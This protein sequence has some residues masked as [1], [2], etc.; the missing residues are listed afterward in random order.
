MGLL[1]EPETLVGAVGASRDPSEAAGPGAAAYGDEELFLMCTKAT[2]R[3][4]E[5]ET[6][7]ARAEAES[8]SLR[9][10]VAELRQ[11]AVQRAAAGKAEASVLGIRIEELEREK[12]AL[13]EF[14]SSH[15]MDF[16]LETD[17]RGGGTC[18][19]DQNPAA[20][21]EEE[22]D[23][24]DDDGADDGASPPPPPPTSPPPEV[25][26]LA[27]EAEEARRALARATC[28]LGAARAVACAATASLDT[29][30][31]ALDA[32]RAARKEAEEEALVQTKAC[33]KLRAKLD[34]ALSS[35][36]S[37]KRDLDA[38]LEGRAKGIEA[39]EARVRT[40]ERE[41]DV[42]LCLV[43]KQDSLI[44]R[45]VLLADD[46]SRPSH[47]AAAMPLP[48]AAPAYDRG[49]FVLDISDGGRKTSIHMGGGSCAAGHPVTVG[50]ANHQGAA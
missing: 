22:E 21:E 39:L 4:V 2:Q 26:K 45:L 33:T 9:S 13:V 7:A 14:V 36:A 16:K 44:A 24:D 28:E 50:V 46:K 19:P 43:E 15:A 38:A 31:A 12:V 25:V 37:A 17:G 6:S 11:E 8:A 20:E 34:R 29:R 3:C 47:G 1:R 42:S 35:D 40:L 27:E 32:A 18:Q 48:R 49:D 30:G 23:D 41:Y 5:L 10:L